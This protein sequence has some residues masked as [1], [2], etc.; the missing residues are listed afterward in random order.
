IGADTVPEL[1]V[2]NKIDLAD[3][4][5]LLALKREWPDAVFVSAHTGAGIEQLRAAG[6]AALPRP[7]G[8]VQAVVH[9]DRG[10]PDARVH[11]RGGGHE[12]VHEAGG[13]RL[14]AR[15]DADLA[16]ALAPYQLHPADRT[17]R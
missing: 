13:T 11:D 14:S 10:D 8:E 3:E 15:V 1:L 4:E 2:V 7:A 9:Y 17:G 6:E 5:R 16:A 12:V